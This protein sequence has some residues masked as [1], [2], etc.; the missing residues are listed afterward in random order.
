[1]DAKKFRNM[2]QK[3]F[4]NLHNRIVNYIKKYQKTGKFP[5]YQIVCMDLD[6]THAQ[7]KIIEQLYPDNIKF[8]NATKR[9]D[10]KVEY[11]CPIIPL[12]DNDLNLEV[13]DD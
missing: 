5:I 7:L 8:H 11:I 9:E 10:C 13:L 4:D 1:M 6:L 2:T 12:D 3:E